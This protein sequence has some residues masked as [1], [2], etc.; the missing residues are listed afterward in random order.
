MIRFRSFI[1]GKDTTVNLFII[2]KEKSPP[3]PINIYKPALKKHNL[4]SSVAFWM[5]R[6]LKC[7]KKKV[8]SIT[9][10]KLK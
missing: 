2:I 3:V 9:L 6:K 5:F 7:F 1:L 4:Y 10:L 8:I